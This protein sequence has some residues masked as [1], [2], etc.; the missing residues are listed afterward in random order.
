MN[1]GVRRKK[2]CVGGKND[3]RKN[4]LRRI[5]VEMPAA[6]ERIA[7]YEIRLRP[8]IEIL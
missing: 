6:L 4:V 1:G 8:K 2:L 5:A 7:G 3:R